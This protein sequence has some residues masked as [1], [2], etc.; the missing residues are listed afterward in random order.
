MSNIFEKALREKLRFNI[1]NG[2]CAT[3]D[4][5]TLKLTTL[6]DIAKQL[7]KTLNDDKDIS[8]ISESTKENEIIQLQFDIVKHIIDTKLEE[9]KAEKDRQENYQTKQKL[10]EIIAKKKDEKLQDMSI[11]ELEKQV[12]NL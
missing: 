6:N 9:A 3:E 12:A 2:V 7:Y 11:E 8:F 4:L 10:L 1:H 5:W